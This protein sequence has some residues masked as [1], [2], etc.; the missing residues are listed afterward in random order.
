MTKR[1]GPAPLPRPIALLARLAALAATAGLP[2]A[3]AAGCA[4]A[5]QNMPCSSDAECRRRDD[6]L[7]YCISSRCVECL[8]SSICGGGAG[9]ECA[10][11]RCVL[12]CRDARDCRSDQLCRDGTCEAR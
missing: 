10:D 12:R 3:A 8:S 2:I 11:G 4:P 9:T 1:T 5:P 7:K 6:D